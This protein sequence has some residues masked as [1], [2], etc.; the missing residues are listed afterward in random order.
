MAFDCKTSETMRDLK[1]ID[2][3]I[4]HCSDS[5]LPQHDNID[6]IRQWHHERKFSDVGYH[7]FIRKTGQIEIG[8]PLYRIG[9]HC[10]GQNLKSI[11]ICLSGRHE[12]TKIQFAAANDLIKSLM[13]RFRITKENVYPHNHFDRKKTCPN[14][15]LNELSAL[16]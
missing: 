8:R 2:K 10:I 5:D 6:T 1:I 13:D 12:F 15:N 9:A 16:R 4:L 7:Y 3:L 14:F 11:G